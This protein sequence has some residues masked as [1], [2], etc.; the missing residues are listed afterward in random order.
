M[1]ENS[2]DNAGELWHKG[3]AGRII[4]VT[5]GA[6]GIGRATCLMAARD[7]A[8]VIALDLDEA[9]LALLRD[10]ARKEGL[11]IL[12][13]SVDVTDAK[14]CEEAADWCKSSAGP[15]TGLVCSAGTTHE[16]PFLKL[17]PANWERVIKL[18]L[19]GSFLISQVIARQMVEAGSAGSIVTI[20]SGAALAVRPG[21]AHYNSSKGGV[22][23][24][25]KSMAVELAAHRIRV[26][27]VAPGS[28]DTP[29]QRR[30]VGAREGGRER[31]LSRIPLARFGQP[32]DIGSMIC[33][34]LSDSASWIT[35]QTMHVNGGSL[36]V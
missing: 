5:G 17:A 22:L 36:L 11:S 35:G 1:T 13:R 18:N 34:L 28:V 10:D 4:A 30:V 26:N 7:G 3:L 24:L 14:A 16:E 27:C 6:S 19:T 32:G 9:A 21:G 2:Q 31:S 23:A 25:T 29:L 8:R 12:T 15:V 20:S 33:F